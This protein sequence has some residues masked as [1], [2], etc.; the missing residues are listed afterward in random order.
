M[1]RDATEFDP[2]QPALLVTYGNTN[3]KHRQLDSDVLVLGRSSTC[4]FA[5][6]SPE[7]AP[8]HCLLVRVHEG[9]KLRDCSGRPG[10]RVNGKTVQEVLLT[11]GDVIQV[12][13]FS[14][15]AHLPAGHRPVEAAPPRLIERLQRSRKKLAER[16]LG[17][18]KALA[19]LQQTEGVT[20]ARLAAEKA[21]LEQQSEAMRV[22]QRDYELR[23]IRLELSE[24]DLATD[25]A[26][27]EKEY[28]AL[29]E[30]IERHAEAVRLFHEERA[31]KER[32]LEE[33]QAGV[34]AELQKVWQ[35]CREHPLA[36]AG[37]A[38]DAPEPSEQ[39]R[40]LDLRARELDHYAEHLRRLRQQLEGVPVPAVEMCRLVSELRELVGEA[41]K[42]KTKPRARRAPRETKADKGDTQVQVAR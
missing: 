33:R 36:S 22:R 9:W 31:G 26:T 28:R 12:G 15:Q 29:Q 16:A 19:A 7:V 8:I 1:R 2:T 35:E 42:T 37:E 11:D 24:R 6:M 14:F 30:E 34:H 38:A 3:R 41:K 40:E 18:R 10:T 23:M 17:L 32:E 13:A 5:L 21:E 25:R 20:S 27:L 4:D 39:A